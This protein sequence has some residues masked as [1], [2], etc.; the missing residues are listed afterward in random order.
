VLAFF[1]PKTKFFAGQT[2][3]IKKQPNISNLRTQ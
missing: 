1:S 3:K 2:P